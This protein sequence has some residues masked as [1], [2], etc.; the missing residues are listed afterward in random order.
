MIENVAP[1]RIR[2]LEDG[3]EIDWD[4]AGHLG[5]FAARPLRLACPCAECVDEMTRRPLLDPAS[6]PGDVRPS[7]LELVGGYG[8]RV[9][10]SDGHSTGIYTFRWL[11]DSCPCPACRASTG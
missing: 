10:W 11:R 8:L 4:G 2:R 1:R 9:F 3:L 7:R 6:V 5:H